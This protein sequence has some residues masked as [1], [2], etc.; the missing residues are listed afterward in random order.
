M[1]SPSCNDESSSLSISLPSGADDGKRNEDSTD[2][3]VD[4]PVD[5]ES[6]SKLAKVREGILRILSTDEEGFDDK[7]QV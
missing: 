5:E 1:E 4:D 3:D 6:R 2:D 7:V